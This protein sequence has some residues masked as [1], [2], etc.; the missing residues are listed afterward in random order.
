MLFPVPDF[1]FDYFAAV[2]LQE[3]YQVKTLELFQD[4]DGLILESCMKPCS[5]LLCGT[6]PFAWVDGI[7]DSVYMA[8]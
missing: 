7:A 2:K 6:D 1:I 3:G 4:I 5:Q 8:V